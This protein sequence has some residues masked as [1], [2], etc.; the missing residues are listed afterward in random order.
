ML[1]HVALH[2]P[3]TIKNRSARTRRRMIGASHR[4]PPSAHRRAAGPATDPALGLPRNQG[5]DMPSLRN[6]HLTRSYLAVACHLRR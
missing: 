2:R 3:P 5:K 4:H 6:P 1:D